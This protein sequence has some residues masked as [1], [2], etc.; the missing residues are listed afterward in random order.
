M[1]HQPVECLIIS[2]WNIKGKAPHL[3]TVGGC[4]WGEGIHCHYLQK[5]VVQ[6]FNEQKCFLLSPCPRYFSQNRIQHEKL[7][8]RCWMVL[9]H[10]SSHPKKWRPEKNKYNVCQVLQTDPFEVVKSAFL[11]YF[12]TSNWWLQLWG[13]HVSTAVGLFGTIEYRTMVDIYWNP[14]VLLWLVSYLGY[15]CPFILS[16]SI[17]IIYG[18]YWWV[19]FIWCKHHHLYPI[20]GWLYAIVI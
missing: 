7:N 14:H 1:K 13:W 3:T 5:M 16:H 10:I 19:V 20:D 8:T 15:Q 11:G 12:V 4:P 9:I 2:V 17:P 18:G 6:W